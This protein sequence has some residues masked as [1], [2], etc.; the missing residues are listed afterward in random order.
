MK[1][2]QIKIVIIGFI[3]T[4]QKKYHHYL[5]KTER[6]GTAIEKKVTYLVLIVDYE[7]T[8]LLNPLPVPHF[9]FASPKSLGLI[10][11]F[12]IRPG[13]DLIEENVGF[14]SF[15]VRL[16]LIGNDKWNL[17]NLINPMAFGHHESWDSSGSN[18]GHHGVTFL[19][20]ID[21]TMPTAVNL[22]WS[23]HVTST[24]HVAESTLTGTMS[25]T[26]TDTRNTSNSSASTPRFSTGLMTCKISKYCELEFRDYGKRNV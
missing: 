24:A 22:G 26:S 10:N 19:G 13:L 9:T 18:G 4:D 1:V 5:R 11:L 7:G 16:D 6:S 3:N 21:P 15:L 20:N 14:L 25:T 2:Y 17:R 12:N 8:T 23:K